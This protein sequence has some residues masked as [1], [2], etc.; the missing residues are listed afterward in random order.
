MNTPQDI[1]IENPGADNL[2]YSALL[3]VNSSFLHITPT[4]ADRI[5]TAI[6]VVGPAALGE[7]AQKLVHSITG[8]EEPLGWDAQ[9]DNELVF[10]FSRARA[11]RTWSSPL[12]SV[13]FL[14]QAEATIGTIQSDVKSGFLVRYGKSLTSTYATTLLSANRISN[15]VAIDDGWY[16]YA[17]ANLRYI[18]NQIFIDGNTFKSSK[19]I[20][21][22]RKNLGVSAGV[23]YSRRN[24]SIT[25]AVN[26]SNSIQSGDTAG[27]L[28]NLT[29][30][31]SLTVA[32]RR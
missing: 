22:N 13:D 1:T 27:T 9:L 29:R 25:F 23:A 16:V 21:Y 2:P 31:G 7:Q 18:F 11:W 20:P 19:S 8:S 24:L 5:D 30:Y 15:P 3:F 26:D 4:V 12:D 10:Q 32:W 6:G 17:G 28:R 14:T